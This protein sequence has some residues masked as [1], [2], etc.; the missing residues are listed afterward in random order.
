M[1]KGSSGGVKI[2]PIR[3]PQREKVSANED[4]EGGERNNEP[5]KRPATDIRRSNT[6]SS[7]SP[8][9]PAAGKKAA[10]SSP[11]VVTPPPKRPRICIRL[12]KHVSDFCL[13]N[14]QQLQSNT[15]GTQSNMRHCNCCNQPIDGAAV[16]M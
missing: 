7:S 13:M 2:R 1:F 12:V 5:V 6:G 15:I 14:P 11:A 10:A 8:S 4:E 3:L 9:G 16:N